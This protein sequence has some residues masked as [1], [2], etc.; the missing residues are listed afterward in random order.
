MPSSG[1]GHFASAYFWYAS[2]YRSLGLVHCALELEHNMRIGKE[3]NNF[4]IC[5]REHGWGIV[6]RTFISFFQRPKLSD[7][8]RGRRGL[9]PERDGRVRCSEGLGVPTGITVS[10][11]IRNHAP[12]VGGVVS[13]LR[14]ALR[15]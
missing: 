8:A 10:V 11:N 6:T 2:A 15:N 12:S 3:T 4:F 5:R 13:I 14:I 7:P 9:Q 1:M